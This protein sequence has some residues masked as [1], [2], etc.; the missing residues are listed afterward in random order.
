MVLNEVRHVPQ[1]PVDTAGRTPGPGGGAVTRDDAGPEKHTQCNA[2]G[3]ERRSGGTRRTVAA[4]APT[5]S[6]AGE[7]EQTA[8]VAMPTPRRAVTKRAMSCAEE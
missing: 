3:G 1:R 2:R 4:T 6:C 5:R 7:K 8:R